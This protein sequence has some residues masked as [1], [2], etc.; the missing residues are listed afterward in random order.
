[1]KLNSKYLKQYKYP[2]VISVAILA[3]FVV[4]QNGSCDSPN[5]S[6][7]AVTA[8]P[9]APAVTANAITSLSSGGNSSCAIIGGGMKCWG[10]NSYGQLGNG[11]ALN[12]MSFAQASYAA[13]SAVTKIGVGLYQACGLVNDVLNCWGSNTSSIITSTSSTSTPTVRLPAGSSVTQ[14]SMSGNLNFPMTVST[15]CIVANGGVKCWGDNSTGIVLGASN[16]AAIAAPI[17]VIPDNSGVTSVSV[18][19]NFACALIN[20]AV[21]CWGT[22]TSGQL[23]N[24]NQ[25]TGFPTGVMNVIQSGA[26]AIATAMQSACA[27]INDGTVQCWG[28]NDLLQTGSG[29]AGVSSASPSAAMGVTG[30]TAIAAGP[31]HFCVAANGGVMCWGDNQSAELGANGNGA[32]SLPVTAVAGG[33]G[34]TLVSAGGTT[35]SVAKTSN[36]SNFSCASDG[37]QIF[38]WGA[39]G[40]QQLGNSVLGTIT[41]SNPVTVDSVP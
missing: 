19:G 12:S 38:C 21:G 34:I 2:A 32:S 26:I 4:F 22:N 41:S 5:Q 37:S 6:A 3:L 28:N 7:S 15:A 11:A 14:I 13:G 29:N 30:A 39:N 36:M 23:G 24:N 1:M 27:V 18:G 25:M 31:Q 8:A 10:G 35:Y 40:Y 33:S 9:P 16:T 17:T 20:G